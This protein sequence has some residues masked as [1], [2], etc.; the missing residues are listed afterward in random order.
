MRDSVPGPTAHCPPDPSSRLLLILGPPASGKTQLTERLAARYE[1]LVLRKDEIKEVLFDTLGLHGADAL[2]RPNAALAPVAEPS[3][4]ATAT[5]SRALSDASFALLFALAQRLLSSERAVL[6]EGNF[7]PTEHESALGRVL[8]G[9]GTQ[10]SEEDGK[11]LGET[12]RVPTEGVQLAQIL[13]HARTQTLT[14]RLQARASDPSRH[15]GHRDLD[16]VARL[17]HNEPEARF[18]DLPGLRLL[19]DSEAPSERELSTLYTALDP[20]IGPATRSSPRR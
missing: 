16:A 15:R 12:T 19:F 14:A 20:W 17:R 5:W 2:A 11:M 18:L 10:V 1:L 8:R 3:G 6:L 4:P 13:C 9:S 7:R